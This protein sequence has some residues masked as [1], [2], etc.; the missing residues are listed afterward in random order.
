MQESYIFQIRYK[1][2]LNEAEKMLLRKVHIRLQHALA[3]TGGAKVG[4]QL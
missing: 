3:Y 1:R 4:I 2:Q